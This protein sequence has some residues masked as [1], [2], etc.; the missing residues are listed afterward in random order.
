MSLEE[1]NCPRLYRIKC[2]KQDPTEAEFFFFLFPSAWVRATWLSFTYL[3]QKE[4][5][6]AEKVEQGRHSYGEIKKY[7]KFR[8]SGEGKRDAVTHTNR[9]V[10][11]WGSCRPMRK[12][13]EFFSVRDRSPSRPQPSVSL[14]ILSEC[15][16]CLVLASA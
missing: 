12:K 6:E 10:E 15:H 13:P 5:C 9:N 7:R 14:G 8:W 2:S 4:Q 1:E 3:N 11:A 16:P